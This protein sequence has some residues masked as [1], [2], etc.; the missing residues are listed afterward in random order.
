ME[1][2][3]AG[4]LDDGFDDDGGQFVSVGGEQLLELPDVVG[5]EVPG[6]R[7]GEELVGE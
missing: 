6:W 2:H 4:A 5:V 1:P 7:R 3:P